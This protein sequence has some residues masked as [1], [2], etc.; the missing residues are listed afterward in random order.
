MDKKNSRNAE[1]MIMENMTVA[2]VRSALRKTRTVLVPLGVLEQHGYHLPL[3]TDIHNAWQLA[4]RVSKRTGALVAPSLNYAFSGGELPGTINISP[5]VMGLVVTDI[6]RSLAAQG[7]RNILLIL[8]H[9]GTEN[10]NALND[11][12]KL[13][14]RNNPRWKNLNIALVRAGRYSPIHRKASREGDL[15]AGYNE[16]SRMLYWAPGLV[17]K[18]IELDSEELVSHM[19]KH[20]DNYL[21]ITKNLDA[22]EIIPFSRQRPDIKV[23]VMGDPSRA[24]AELGEKIVRQMVD[25]VCGL[26]LKMEKPG[27]KR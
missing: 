12:L 2:E 25:G 1:A 26:V 18:K 11:S 14:L 13:F 5:A 21:E 22:E 4:V 19:R 15:H 6:C 10:L 17:R 24:S 23:G 9:G 16:T 3:S 7:F 20:Q 8:G 27:R